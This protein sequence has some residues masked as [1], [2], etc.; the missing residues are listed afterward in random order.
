FRAKLKLEQDADGKWRVD[1]DEDWAKEPPKEQAAD[2]G[3]DGAAAAA[4]EG[5]GAGDGDGAQAAADDGKA[6]P[7]KAPSKSGGPSSRRRTTVPGK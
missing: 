2:A 5:A 1:F 4:E 7:R 6:K 3:G